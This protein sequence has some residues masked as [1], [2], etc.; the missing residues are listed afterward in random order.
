MD[1]PD[2][3]ALLKDIRAC[4]RCA[5]ALPH[6]PRPIVQAGQAARIL[7]V[8]QAPGNRVHATGMP[9]DDDS[10]E[11]LREWTGLD[12]DTFYDPDQVA[13]IPMGLCY[14]GKG[15]G[16]DLPPRKECAPVWHAPLLEHLPGLRLTLLVG[17]YAH[18]AW[19]PPA[20][21][22]SMTEA[23]RRLDEMPKGLFPLPHPAWRSRLWM[24]RQ[25]WFETEVLPV[26][27]R[28]VKRALAEVSDCA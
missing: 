19:L 27:R 24:K 7:I 22:P 15:N 8:G 6:E 21:R 25:P 12:R 16:G 10:G 13:L 28:R 11:R 4:R 20:L 18:R 3:A 26:L 23:V 9:W 5:S 14:P 2:L 17:T 1:Q